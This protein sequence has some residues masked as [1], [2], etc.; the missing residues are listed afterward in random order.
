MMVIDRVSGEISHHQFRDFV[1]LCPQEHQLVLNDTKVVPARFFSDDE[2]VEMVRTDVRDET[3][4]WCLVKPGKRMKVGR[5]V[6]VGGCRGEVEEIDEKGQRLIRW[7]V[8]PDLEKVGQLALP[9]Y[10]GRVSDEADR[11]RYQTVY[12]KEEGA[13]A[14][15][16]AGLH[17]TPEVLGN[18]DPVYVTLHVGVGTFRPVKVENPEEHDMHSERYF[19]TEE[20]A[21]KINEAEK[22]LSVGTTV[23]RVLE[24]VGREGKPLQAGGGETDIFIYPPYE[25]QV[26]DALL[27]NFHLPKSTLLMLVSSLA[28]RELMLEAYAKALEERYR[29]YSYGD[30]MLIV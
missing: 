1:D 28:G 25:F 26:V 30:C 16:T 21:R 10:M 12:A 23:T 24:H 27:T 19:L 5:E 18:F 3:G 11:D 9:H 2:R 13:I 29:F 22:V 7:N 20:A 8:V 15:P 17:F 6:I 14:A 4:W